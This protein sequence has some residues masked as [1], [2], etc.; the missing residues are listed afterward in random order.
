MIAILLTLIIVGAIAL[1]VAGVVAF[2]QTGAAK[3]HQEVKSVKRELADANERVSIAQTAL[4][5]I[6]SGDSMPILRASDA[7]ANISK[8]YTKEI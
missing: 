4:I 2:F 8:S 1:G 5:E 6:A 3:A 7:L